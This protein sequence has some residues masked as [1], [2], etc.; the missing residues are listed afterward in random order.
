MTF[1][2]GALGEFTFSQPIFIEVVSDE[3][4]HYFD[5]TTIMYFLDLMVLI[6]FGTSG[7]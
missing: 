4:D 1:S 7:L 2:F 3:V 5:P 6:Y